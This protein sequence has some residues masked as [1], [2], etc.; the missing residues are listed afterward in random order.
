MYGGN[1]TFKGVFI[2]DGGVKLKSGR[3]GPVG[4]VKI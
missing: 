4:L 1:C 2:Q 3:G